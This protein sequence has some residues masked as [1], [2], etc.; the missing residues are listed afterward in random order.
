MR[1]TFPIGEILA[2]VLVFFLVCNP[3]SL[4]S[5][6]NSA[7]A[8]S[9]ESPTFVFSGTVVR[10]GGTSN[11][12]EIR[13]KVT[14]VTRSPRAIGKLDGQEVSILTSKPSQ[15]TKNGRY[16]FSAVG[17]AAG[18]TLTLREVPR[19]AVLRPVGLSAVA[20]ERIMDSDLVV[21]GTVLN[22]VPQPPAANTADNLPVRLPSEHQ[23][24]EKILQL[25]VTKVLSGSTQK[26]VIPVRVETSQDVAYASGDT[27]QA[28]QVKIG[29]SK[30]FALRWDAVASVW[31]AT[32]PSDVQPINLV[33]SIREVL[34]SAPKKEP[35]PEN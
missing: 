19:H 13:V 6:E 4:F 28:D 1:R 12:N 5:Q 27:G 34:A 32:A 14:S 20:S 35:S 23:S 22:I 17:D 30:V 11:P 9:N 24:H 33:N 8:L 3:R 29:E 31:T 2:L 7:T 16:T 25:Q 10:K 18:D 26:T 21:Q 15:Y